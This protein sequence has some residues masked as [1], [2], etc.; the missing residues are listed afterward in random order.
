MIRNY[1]ES[2]NV[3]LENITS[4]AEKYICEIKDKQKS[5]HIVVFDVGANI[6]VYSL[7]FSK[8]NNAAIYSFEPFI[9]SY[10]FL[11]KNIDFN[12]VN[13]IKAFNFGLIDR[14]KKLTMGAPRKKSK[15]LH[16]W[17]NSDSV[18]SGCKTIYHDNED[19]GIVCDFIKGDDILKEIDID[20]VDY[21]KID[22]EGSEFLALKGMSKILDSYDPIL[23]LEINVKVL[24]INGIRLE[25]MVEYL[26]KYNYKSYILFG[27]DVEDSKD[28]KELLSKVL[29]GSKD[30]V[31]YK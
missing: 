1:T 13:N 31:F 25:D 28:I 22:T 8:I 30:Y 29:I 21:I 7:A 9:E 23:Q 2:S 11:S 16:W 5:Q 20:C 14:K 18:E 15:T 26:I 10:Q 3:I 12:H 24:D 17:N 27:E 6:G 19:E 4:K